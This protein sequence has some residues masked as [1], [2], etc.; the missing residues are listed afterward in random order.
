MTAVPTPAE[1]LAWLRPRQPA[2]LDRL[3]AWVGYES[4][5][6]EPERVR[7]LAET[8]A[9]DFA[10][11][12]LRAA[13]HEYA[14]E[15]TLAGAGAGAP[16]LLIGHL[17]TVWAAG[18][19]AR[20]PFRVED[21]RAFGPGAYDMKAGIVMARFALEALL[22]LGAAPPPLTLLLV[23]DE[24]TGSRG[25][26]ALTEARARGA[27]AA[28]VLEPGAE[29]GGGIKIARKGIALYR[30]AAHGVAAHA[31]VDFERGASA[32]V[33]LARCVVE[34]ADWSD[35][36]AGFT[37]NP[38]VLRGGTH[39]NVVAEEAQAELDVRAWSA[40]ALDTVDARLRG[41]RSADPRVRLELAGGL[42]R[43]PM[44]PTPASLALAAQAQAIGRELGLAL[45]LARTGGGSDGNFTAACGV[46]TLD[47]LGAAGAGAHAAHEHVHLPSWAARTA[48]LASLLATVAAAPAP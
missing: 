45:P 11:L 16:L 26:R 1:V 25:S 15:L 23:F 37:L 28:L 24:E 4:P 21:E 12:G 7:A 2:M 10:A 36:A 17:D 22:A 43:P 33:A 30:L 38:G 32:V 14:L 20:M 13:A 39:S 3:R 19:L 35:P 8:V 18:T 47:G 9:A 44:E 46:P 27:R 5:T 29:P 34:A 6:A 31:G 42:N 48:L 41:L 40:A